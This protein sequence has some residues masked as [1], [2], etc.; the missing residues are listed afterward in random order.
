V[1]IFLLGATG[2]SDRRILRSALQR[3]HEVTAFVRD[4]TKLLSVVDVPVP[5]NLQVSIGDIS[6]SADIARVMIGHDVVINAAGRVTEGTPFTQLVQV[7]IDSTI[8]ALGEGGRL[9]QFG[10]RQ[11]GLAERPGN[12]QFRSGAPCCG[13]GSDYLSLYRGMSLADSGKLP[14]HAAFPARPLQRHCWRP[15][16]KI[17]CTKPY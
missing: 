3:A 2:N 15:L 11:A 12:T 9:W 7:V 13:V 5:P 14:H 8:T 10:V 6:K 1:K 16:R 4:H 17:T